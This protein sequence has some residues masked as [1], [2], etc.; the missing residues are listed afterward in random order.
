[1]T[2]REAAQLALQVQDA[3]NLSGVVHDLPE[4]MDAIW[5]E[6]YG[7]GTDW[8]NQ[9]PIVRLILYKLCSL[10]GLAVSD[11]ESNIADTLVGAVEQ[12][13]NGEIVTSGN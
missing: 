4:V 2:Y 11:Y 12:I 8:V 13:A 9:N 6:G 3:S 1:M 7:K 10:N 5:I